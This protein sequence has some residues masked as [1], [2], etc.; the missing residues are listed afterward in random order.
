M[1]QD[2][3]AANAQ[4]RDPEPQRQCA[5]PQNVNLLGNAMTL[6]LETLSKLASRLESAGVLLPTSPT[7]SGSKDS[8]PQ[9]LQSSLA[10]AIAG[11]RER[12]AQATK[13]MEDLLD[14]LDI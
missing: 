10:G 2:R 9:P 11:E 7:G 1:E 4:L 5:V 3:Y 13:I 12:L 14:R 8:G 6:N